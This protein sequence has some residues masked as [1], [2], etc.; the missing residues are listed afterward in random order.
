MANIMTKRG[1]Q[2]NV[3]T[4]EHY[5]DTKADL[6]NIPKSQITLGSTAVVL[7]DENDELGI[8]I[9]G[10]DKQ[11]VP[12]AM[13][14]SGGGGDDSYLASIIDGSV[15]DII[16]P[17]GVTKIKGYAFYRCEMATHLYI[18]NSV[19]EIDD[20]AFTMMGNGVTGEALDLRL[21]DVK[22]INNSAFAAV[23]LIKSIDLPKCEEVGNTAFAA[24]TNCES[25][26][27]NSIKKINANA[28]SG[29]TKVEYIYLGPNCTS[30]SSQAFA[31]VPITCKVECGF[32][33][34]AVSGFPAN[35]G[36]NGNPAD[37]DITYNVSAPTI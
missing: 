7:K 28:F 8:Y 22:K 17:D 10:S 2:D 1:S 26:K 21:D 25:I 5:C 3:I 33:D 9:A 30:I 12:V 24:C 32:A 36:W 34:S 13:S 19:T 18:P 31:G 15:T 23:T 37:L 6:A 27:L 14:S 11:W 20:N 29:C 16:I 35:G 4:Y